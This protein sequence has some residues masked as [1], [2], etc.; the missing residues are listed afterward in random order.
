MSKIILASQSPRRAELLSKIGVEFETIPSSFEEQLDQSKDPEEVAKEIAL[1][2]ALNV[3]AQFPDAYV[4]GSDTVVALR[5]RQ[6]EKPTDINDA[7]EML[8]ALAGK[9]S[10]VTTGIVIICQNMNI[11]LV[12][13]STTRVFFKPGSEEIQ[14]LREAYLATDDWKDKAAGY[15][16]QSGAGPLIDHYDG[17]YDT[18][19][20]LPTFKLS[21]M[22]KQLDLL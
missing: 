20:G 2:K 22:L 13:G 11:K 8:T 10:I 16:I 4:I 9:Q 5:N 19:V 18:I 14:V 1:G 3:A 7:R 21:A 17:D 12:D 6:M 15:G